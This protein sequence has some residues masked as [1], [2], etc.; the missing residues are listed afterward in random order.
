MYVGKFQQHS[1]CILIELQIIQLQENKLMCFIIKHLITKASAE[2]KQYLSIVKA[3]NNDPIT[4]PKESTGE[5]QNQQALGYQNF[6][7]K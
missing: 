5:K 3:S 2:T 6:Y 1:K 7:L 4:S